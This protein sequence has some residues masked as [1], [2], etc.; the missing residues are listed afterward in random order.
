[1]RGIIANIESGSKLQ[2]NY[3]GV[4]LSS[5]LQGLGLAMRYVLLFIWFIVAF[6]AH[7]IT[8]RPDA[9][10]RYVVQRGDTL[11]SIANCFLKNPWEWKQLWRGNP[12]IQNPNKLYPGAVIAL[13]YYHQKP[14]LRVLSNG[15]IKLSPHTRPIPLEDPILPI[16]IEDIKPFLNG[17]IILDNDKLKH[18]PFIIAFMTE[19]MMAGQG[20]EVY[21]QDLCPIPPPIG[22]VKTFAIYRRC[23]IYR[24]PD[25]HN[26]IGYKAS[27]VGFAELVHN[28][29]PATVVITDITQGVRLHDRV[30]PNTFPA[31]DPYFDP[32]TPVTP[33]HGF[34]IDLAGDYTQGG[35]GL[36]AVINRGHDAG[37]QAGD[38]LG[39]YSKPR[40]V[41]NNL[42]HYREQGPCQKQCVTLPPERIG[43]VMI[44]RVFSQ[45]SYA[46][47]VRSIRAIT[48]L[49][50]VTNP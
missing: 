8:L 36:V 41:K 19:H 22:E 12:Q 7:A 25:K 20:D 1:M 3:A 4:F 37:L 21:V 45:T 13:R 6:P 24:D 34:I 27:L 26:I 46:L 38:V 49:D 18:T 16:P 50:A 31:F 10:D 30:M 11:W 39:V 23:G 47:V 33:V 44:F 17:S 40:V 28:G 2:I 48:K 32:K 14:Y 29:N 42:F 35:V 15:T 5:G 9:P 43:E